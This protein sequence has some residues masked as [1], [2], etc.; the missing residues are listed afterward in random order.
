VG[1][2]IGWTVTEEFAYQL[3]NSGCVSIKALR[4]PNGA[5]REIKVTFA[6]G[7]ILRLTL[8]DISQPVAIETSA[9][10]WPG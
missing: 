1:T 8:P 4:D 3:T 5:T 10:P 2:L 9:G 6:N 7:A